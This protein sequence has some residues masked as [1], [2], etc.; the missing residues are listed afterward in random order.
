MATSGEQSAGGG[1]GGFVFLYLVPVD[2]R[3]DGC[4]RVTADGDFI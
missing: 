2:F 1:T 3:A 4:V